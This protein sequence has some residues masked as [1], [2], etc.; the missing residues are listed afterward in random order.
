MTLF[1]FIDP[2]ASLSGQALTRSPIAREYAWDFTE[3]EYLLKDGRPYIVEG[4]E[5]LKI[6]IYKALK[7]KRC[8]HMAY[9]W[10]YGVDFHELIGKGYSRGYT[11]SEVARMLREALLINENITGITNLEVSFSEDDLKVTFVAETVFGE[12]TIG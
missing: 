4:K 6:W 10:N 11:H 5:A 2:A 7:T 8:K 1:P 3:N 12:V 9:S